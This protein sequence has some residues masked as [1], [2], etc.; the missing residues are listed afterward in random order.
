VS[1]AKT[2]L[3]FDFGLKHIGIAAGQSVSRTA[4]EITTIGAR[5]GEPDWVAVDGLLAEWRPD[6]VLVGLPLNMDE[7]MSEMGERAEAFAQRL[8]KRYSIEVVMVDERLTS[9]AARELA[10]EPSARH[11]IA[12]RLIAE[13]Y[14]NAGS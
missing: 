11:A 13:T 4:S 3:A 7:T 8:R 5:G 14:L 2:V 10:R 6:V 1:A 12:A 9:V